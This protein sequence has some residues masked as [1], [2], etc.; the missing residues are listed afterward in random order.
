MPA[1]IPLLLLRSQNENY[2]FA[3]ALQILTPMS[4]EALV[5]HSKSKNMGTVLIAAAVSITFYVC[6]YYALRPH[7]PQI[8]TIPPDFDLDAGNYINVFTY[9]KLQTFPIHF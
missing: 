9:S 2:I 6:L 5:I 1:R 8:S 7:G 3:E 4:R